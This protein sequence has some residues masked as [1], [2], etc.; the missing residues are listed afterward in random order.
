M[1]EPPIVTKHAATERNTPS[2]ATQ[3]SPGPEES[4]SG[5]GSGARKLLGSRFAIFIMLFCVTGFLGIPVLWASPAFSKFEK[6]I[7][8]IVVT[9]YTSTLIYGTGWIV[10][11]VYRMYAE[12]LG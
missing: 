4:K 1:T 3:Q 11:R 7:W 10:M 2:V 9:I 12:I 8:S 5:S 6:A